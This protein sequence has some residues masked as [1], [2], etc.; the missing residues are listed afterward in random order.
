[1]RRTP[2]WTEHVNQAL[3]NAELEAVKKSTQ[4]GSPFGDPDW[5]SKTAKRLGLESTLRQRGRPKKTNY[6]S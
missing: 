2:G 3:T 4:R 1:M 5:I 6:E